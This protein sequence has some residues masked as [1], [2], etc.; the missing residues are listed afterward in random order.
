[1]QLADHGTHRGAW[2]GRPPS[3]GPVSTDEFAMYRLDEGR[4]AEIWVTADN[5]RLV[6]LS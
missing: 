6:G 3:G 5:A 4:I 2:L 1:V